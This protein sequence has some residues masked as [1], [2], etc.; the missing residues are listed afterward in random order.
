[1]HSNEQQCDAPHNNVQFVLSILFSAPN[2][3]LSPP[4]PSL[5]SRLSFPPSPIKPSLETLQTREGQWPPL[6]LPPSLSHIYHFRLFL[7]LS[8]SVY[9]LLRLILPLSSSLS[10]QLFSSRYDHYYWIVTA[11]S[12]PLFLTPSSVVCSLA[13]PLLYSP[14]LAQRSGAAVRPAADHFTCV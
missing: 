1:M 13:H 4:L 11:P 14:C 2:P 3:L 9:S 6:S 10:E 5:P 12:P 8:V 7:F